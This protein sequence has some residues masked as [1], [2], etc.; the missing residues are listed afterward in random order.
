MRQTWGSTA[1]GQLF[2]ATPPWSLSLD[3]GRFE[4][5][6]AGKTVSGEVAQLERLSIK[7]GAMWAGVR[8]EG[9]NGQAIAL[10]GI[11][12]GEAKKLSEALTA[13]IAVVRRQ[14]YIGALLRE[15]GTHAQKITAWVDQASTLE[16]I[17]VGT[18]CNCGSPMPA[19][20]PDL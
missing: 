12:N 8:V 13:S 6:I 2:T 17:L 9:D 14:E 7:P 20:R 4:L 3:G 18:T 5:S 15:F 16:S 10:D 1:L 11:A 19:Q